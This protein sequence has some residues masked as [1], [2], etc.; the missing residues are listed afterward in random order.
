[1]TLNSLELPYVSA[2]LEDELDLLL[3]DEFQDTSP[4]QLALFLKLAN[5]A[6]HAVFVGDIKQAIYAFRGSDPELMQAV[7]RSVQQKGGK[8]DI[9]KSSWPV[10][11]GCWIHPTRWPVR[12]LWH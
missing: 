11:G 12:R 10:S 5:L 6:K 4:I 8:T 3:V 9:L 1:M 2:A 7:L